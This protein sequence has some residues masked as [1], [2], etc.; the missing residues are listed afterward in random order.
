MVGVHAN[1][2]I[3]LCTLPSADS[4]WLVGWST[5]V[6]WHRIARRHDRSEGLQSCV[7]TFSSS[8][9]GWIKSP[10]IVWLLWSGMMWND[11]F[12]F[13][14]S[15]GN[16]FYFVLET[17]F[18]RVRSIWSWTWL[19]KVDGNFQTLRKDSWTTWQ[20]TRCISVLC[21]LMFSQIAHPEVASN[22][23]GCFTRWNPCCWDSWSQSWTPSRVSSRPPWQMPAS[24]CPRRS[25]AWTS[26]DRF[27]WGSPSVPITLGLLGRC[28]KNGSP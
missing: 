8:V 20:S 24:T 14:F 12:P 2:T 1:V 27:P 13:C 4:C 6:F 23:G 5:Q 9:W 21:F 15:N 22:L 19:M 16:V 17:L 28:L 26:A 25:P 10:C 18:F 11:F 3:S 7:V